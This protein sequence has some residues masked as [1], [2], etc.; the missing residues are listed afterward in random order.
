MPAGVPTATSVARKSPGWSQPTNA[1]TSPLRAERRSNHP[2]P[3]W[4]T[5]IISAP[6][7]Y[8]RSRRVLPFKSIAKPAFSSPTGQDAPRAAPQCLVCPSIPSIPPSG[9]IRSA[10]ARARLEDEHRAASGR[11]E[12]PFRPAG[13]GASG[14]TAS[15]MDAGRGKGKTRS[16]LSLRRQPGPEG[17]RIT[18]GPTADDQKDLTD[19]KA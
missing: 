18:A 6:R 9:Q 1:K 10:A 14:K 3:F 15:G 2:L 4:V 5:I 12:L 19:R 16:G 17:R 11:G 13:R 7:R 8:F